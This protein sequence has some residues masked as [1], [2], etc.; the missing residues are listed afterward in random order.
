MVVSSSSSIE[1]SMRESIFQYDVEGQKLRQRCRR[2][3]RYID[4]FRLRW[5][6]MPPNT[7]R[8]PQTQQ[9]IVSS[10]LDSPLSAARRVAL[11]R[12]IAPHLTQIQLSFSPPFTAYSP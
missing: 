1:S 12:R 6:S 11:I 4:G 2:V 8:T 9:T 7:G 5:R 3:S 10:F